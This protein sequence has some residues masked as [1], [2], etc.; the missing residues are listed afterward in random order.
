M[1]DKFYYS[2]DELNG[3]F[4]IS[5]DDVYLQ[6]V[7]IAE[8]IKSKYDLDKV[9]LIGVA[10]GGMIPVTIVSHQLGLRFQMLDLHSYTD[11]ESGD[12]VVE[13]QLK[14]NKDK[15]NIIIDDIY[16][17]GKTFEY[18]NSHYQIDKFYY[19]LDKRDKDYGWVVFPWESEE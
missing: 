18:I 3:K 8:D 6:C 15:V 1:S 2:M 10:R 5:W 7:K 4:Y 16:D 12:M 13:N 11:K 19:V 14:L 9:N 17:T